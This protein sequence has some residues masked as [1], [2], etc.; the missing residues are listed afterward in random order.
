MIKK[1]EISH[2]TILFAVA[3]LG[4]LWLLYLVKDIVLLIYIGILLMLALGPGVNKLDKWG[5]PRSLAILLNYLVFFGLIF[6]ALFLLAGPLLQQSRLLVQQIIKFGEQIGVGNWLS[7]IFRDPLKNILPLSGNIFRI[8]Q[9]IFN[10]LIQVFSVFVISF[11]L[12]LDRKKLPGYLSS[13]LG[14]R[15]T[16]KIDK[17]IKEAEKEVGHWLWG[18]LLLM[19]IVGVLTYLVLLI[20]R[21]PYA[22]PLAFLAGLLEALPN[23]GPVMAAIPAMIIGF[24]ISPLMGFLAAI[25]FFVIQQLESN[26]ITPKVMQ[27]VTGVNPIVTL[28]GLLIGFRLAGVTGA[29]FALPT[30]LIIKVLIEKAIL[31]RIKRTN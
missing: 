1:V 22:L 16:K 13:F 10:N 19:V 30:V 15:K 3:V 2:K 24:T 4:F 27:G 23:I 18:Q 7:E 21:F 17:V 5:F 14:N 9:T 28:L 12:I 6:L 8:T 26:L 11:Y 25:V 20:L 31:P 29:I